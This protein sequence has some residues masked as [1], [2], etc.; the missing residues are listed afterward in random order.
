MANKNQPKK[1]LNWRTLV[2]PKYLISFGI[3][4][5]AVAATLGI[6]KYNSKNPK[7]A[8]NESAKNLKNEF[9][10][11]NA[12]P[13]LTFVDASK[14]KNIATFNPNDGVL[15]SVTYKGKN[16]D[17][18]SF[19]NEYYQEHRSLPFLNIRYGMFDFYNE[20]LEAVTAK[21]FFVFTDWFMKNVSWGPEII[22]LKEFSIVKG[23]EL[24]GNN[25]TLGSHSNID[26]EQT[27][28]KF[29]PDAFFGSIPMH[30]TLSGQGN[31]PDSLL[32]K[33]NKKLLTIDELK[34]FL[35]KTVLFNSQANITSDTLSN[36]SF[37]TLLDNRSLINK[38]VF[39]VKSKTKQNFANYAFSEVEKSRL[40]INSD[41]ETLIFANDIEQAK[42]KFAKHHSFYLNKD[43]YKSLTNIDDYIFEEKTIIDSS[44]IN[45]THNGQKEKYLNL[46]FNDAT[47]FV[48]FDAIDNVEY[49]NSKGDFELH[50]NV[51]SLDFALEQ[52]KIEFNNLFTDIE[53][54]YEKWISKNILF[55]EDSFAKFN[56]FAQTTE[57]IE[58]IS[59]KIIEFNKIISNTNKQHNEIITKLNEDQQKSKQKV[60]ELKNKLTEVQQKI[61]QKQSELNETNK[62]SISFELFKLEK[63]K[64]DIELQIFEYDNA[65][66]TAQRLID[67]NKAKIISEEQ[68]K[69]AR[70]KLAQAVNEKSK[71]EKSINK[72]QITSLLRSVG[73][74]KEFIEDV[75]NL[76]L[77]HNLFNQSE[78]KNFKTDFDSLDSKAKYIREVRNFVDIQRSYYNLYNRHLSGETFAKL[79]LQKSEFN[80]YG[81]DVAYLPTQL[82]ALDELSSLS[83][84]T[85]INWREYA[86]LDGFIRSNVD[87][88]V[89]PNKFFAYINQM[90]SSTAQKA[91]LEAES[92][93]VEEKFGNL[94]SSFVND[95]NIKSLHD[96]I[97]NKLSNSNIQKLRLEYQELLKE[98]DKVVE[99]HKINADVLVKSG[100]LK[101]FAS[102]QTE[103]KKYIYR[104]QLLNLIK[105]NN[106][107]KSN[108]ASFTKV[109]DNIE[110]IFAISQKEFNEFKYKVA[111][112]IENM[113][114]ISQK[115]ANEY[116]DS[117]DSDINEYLK[118]K[119]QLFNK[120]M[121]ELINNIQSSDIT[122]TKY[123]SD[124][125]AIFELSS[126]RVVE[127][128][129][130]NLLNKDQLS[131]LA[132][133]FADSIK[134]VKDLVE[135]YSIEFMSEYATSYFNVVKNPIY[136]EVDTNGKTDNQ[137]LKFI[138]TLFNP[139]LIYIEKINKFN[140][141]YSNSYKQKAEQ[142]K[143]QIDSAS[144]QSTKDLLQKE[145]DFAINN[146]KYYAE[147]ATTNNEFN[148]DLDNIRKIAALKEAFNRDDVPVLK[149]RASILSE[150]LQKKHAANIPV[151]NAALDHYF[152]NSKRFET[153]L[154]SLK[155]E[156]IKQTNIVNN[157]SDKFISIDKEFNSSFENAIKH[158]QNIAKYQAIKSI[159]FANINAKPI[160][161]AN[162]SLITAKS[163]IELIDKLTSLGIINKEISTNLA[164]FSKNNI[165]EVS[166][167]S[168]EKH[169]TNLSFVLS[170]NSNDSQN[171]ID[172]LLATKLAKFTIDAKLD[173][174]QYPHTLRQFKD[175]L[176][177]AGYTTVIQPS[178][179]KEEGTRIVTNEK[180]EQKTIS[181]YSLFTEAYDG[182]TDELLAS[183]PYAGEW[184]EGEH[185]VKKV[186]DDGEI[187]FS[188]ENGKYLGFRP[189]SRIGLWSLIAMNNPN[190]KG[191][192]IDFLKFVAAHEYGHHMTLN[193]AQDLGDKAQKPL[194][195]SALVPG[196]TP[197]VNNYY[198]RE[199]IGLYLKARTHLELN[200]SPLLNQPNVVSENNEGEYLLFNQPKKVDGK[201]VINENTVENSTDVWG[202]KVGEEDLKAAMENAKRRF[203]QTYEG[204][205]KA[206]EARRKE[207]GIDSEQDKKWLEIFDL[208]LM[209]TLDQNSGTLNPTKYSDEKH[210]VKYMVKDE[211]GNWS[212]KKASLLM[213]KNVIKDGQGN[214]IQFEEN[215]ENITPKIVEGVKDESGKYTKITKVLVYNKDGSPIINV[216]LNVDFTDK[217]SGFYQ[218]D[219]EGNNVN[220]EFINERIRQAANTISALIVK[221]Y[222]IN[223]W[224]FATTDTSTNSKTYV[225]YPTYAE[226]FNN[227]DK[228]Y[229]ETILKPY[230]DYI[231]SRNVT[232]AELTDGT[233][234]AKYYDNSGKVV[235]DATSNDEK[236]KDPKYQTI[237]QENYYLNPFKN[238]GKD[239]TDFR[240][241]ITQLY[242]AEGGNYP[243]ATAGAK[244]SLWLSATEQYLP[245]IMHKEAFRD[246][247][248]YHS[249]S[250]STL[251][252]LHQLPIQN[253]YNPYT[254]Q[255]VGHK[256]DS[257]TYLMVNANGDVISPNPRSADYP[258]FWEMTGMKINNNLLVKTVEDSLFNSFYIT[259]DQKRLFG[260]EIIF[261]T[262]D[263]FVKFASVDTTRAQLDP[264]KRVVNWDL[265][266]VK[267]KFD[268]DR[269]ARNLE[270]TLLNSIVSAKEKERLSALVKSK[271]KQQLANE[272]M[273]R[274]TKSKLAFF[275][276]DLSLGEIKEKIAQDPSNVYRYGWIFDKELGFGLYK[277]DDVVA[278]ADE[279]KLDRKNWE[280]SVKELFDTYD[281]FAQENSVKLTQFTLYDHLILDN[282][283]QMYSTQVHYSFQQDKW[284]LVDLL[285]AFVKAFTKKTRP[286]SDVEQYFKTKTERKFNEFF[287]DYTY[288]FAEVINR[289]NLQ[290]TYSPANTEFANLPSF[291]TNVNEANTGLE[292]VID[293]KATE[294]WS[295]A[296]INFGGDSRFSV[297]QSVMNSQNRLNN[298]TKLRAQKLGTEFKPESF[299]TRDAF[300]DDQNKNS[301]YFGKFKSINNGWFKD[302]WYRDMLNFRLYDDNGNPIED[303]TIRIQDLEGNKVT[304]R[305][306]AYWQ[307]YIQS[308]GVG[309]RNLSNIWRNAQKDA[310]A[311]FGYLN[312]EDAKK[313]NYLVFEDLETKEIKTLKINKNY[314]SNMFYYKTQHIHNE[315]K[316]E[317]RHYLKDEK[318]SYSDSNGEH[319]G[320]G[321]TAWV[322]DYA[323]MSN[324]ADKLLTP[325]HEYK[326]YFAADEKGTKTLNVDLGS[327]ESVSE[328]GK[329]FSQAPTAVYIKEING[330]KVP[331]M[332]VGVQFNG[333]KQ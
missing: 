174:K 216:P 18:N 248:L 275:V 134:F 252:Q 136:R 212:F 9:L 307:Y 323:I 197:N 215:G 284:G 91:E 318:Y 258:A 62:D 68:I 205:Q 259:R 231:K 89:K 112:I 131:K 12:I 204:L 40:N 77:L 201:V 81:F 58:A 255:I 142:I 25:L 56:N 313:V 32:Y 235:Y 297:R 123:T 288:S 260:S 191:L 16:L 194:F 253:W 108:E 159:A 177:V 293:G 268:I 114:K 124:L 133:K 327:F 240:E 234:F 70:A 153:G 161:L 283:T 43:K 256:L 41:Y 262:Y 274:F 314:T 104:D 324:Y 38:K 167:T 220:V 93:K 66:K 84:K 7:L 185:I 333:S 45:N 181:T 83:L 326:I 138:G 245:N 168:V 227:A 230:L 145:Y 176:S 222:S 238:K 3:I 312:N 169:G 199:V 101:A 96:S 5:G 228:N 279:S 54:L 310:V 300:S 148:K 103:D 30:S 301:N 277:S 117:L 88:K 179:I 170:Q 303:D 95:A 171:E 266:Y 287:S 105:N 15:G 47:N 196:T 289:D 64:N 71:L 155:N 44:F 322:S 265:D 90:S 49:Q 290:I 272:I 72:D 94:K 27:T 10:D 52:A 317:S 113:L 250:E 65:I 187:E 17:Y 207:N 61:Q 150:E 146:S 302:R 156:V 192:S 73:I 20:Y 63:E 232:T 36:H 294:K 298:E 241:F 39:A 273:L 60:T 278:Q 100:T 141:D 223:G 107:L 13:V 188:I 315:E 69:D 130:S 264:V 79:N 163:K 151:Y 309:K 31:A 67:E 140:E 218:I 173:T 233:E 198:S 321:F 166:L 110:K 224:D 19:L 144:D 286:T 200:S 75:I 11:P 139:L 217:D 115:I 102:A 26:K 311:L 210:P 332:R 87:D 46:T 122:D 121:S 180:G 270:S 22:T 29:F 330:E 292:Y 2:W 267:S 160:D 243:A 149:Y 202:H 53:S 158:A 106:H 242:L 143:A 219:S 175:M 331:V 42:T 23:V 98:L 214:F 328:N 119:D 271:D 137:D 34:G 244:Q 48:L 236:L 147:I 6:F 261:K 226:L 129:Q 126:R 257:H 28:I 76:H 251:K 37:R 14:E 237:K 254:K 305:P 229:N 319:K 190:Y 1:K 55:S 183:V 291:I 99:K 74:N 282:K 127:F 182:F 221:D 92:K 86:N 109:M 162:T 195:G 276:K 246:S 164:E 193:S 295:S 213:L 208:W 4:A 281:K 80:L 82:I 132:S 85:Q 184:L 8:K 118:Q 206:T 304:N 209:N 320:T 154:N 269:F 172:K 24:R 78:Y 51:Q 125:Q 21:D 306:Q 35:S 120:K 116:N 247:F 263:E 135:K 111:K 308:Q 97:G 50:N 33:I 203:L 189:D 152:E 165:F 128:K 225:S 157:S 59:Q 285:L 280:I 57:N 299:I 239:K 211:Q 249:F 178:N 316:P 186:N 325:N 329:T 296:Q